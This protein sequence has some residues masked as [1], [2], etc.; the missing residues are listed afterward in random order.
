MQL[1]DVGDLVLEPRLDPHHQYRFENQRVVARLARCLDI[2]RHH[3]LW[4]ARRMLQYVGRMR[5]LEGQVLQVLHQDGELG[6]AGAGF[7]EG[8]VGAER[9]LVVIHR[10]GC[11]LTVLGLRWGPGSTAAAGGQRTAMRAAR[12]VP[13]ARIEDQVVA[14]D[15]AFAGQAANEA[16]MGHDGDPMPVRPRRHQ[17]PERIATV[18][19]RFVGLVEIGPPA[20]G[21]MGEIERGPAGRERAAMAAD[22]AVETTQFANLGLDPDRQRQPF[23]DDLR[24]FERARIRARNQLGEVGAG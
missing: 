1:D 2:D 11:H 7:R 20:F 21:Q 17:A 16:P 6:I 4:H 22:V 8:W 13:S 9:Q 19:E 3:A 24:R 14:V 23:G 5:H 18:P 12:S 15:H 10:V